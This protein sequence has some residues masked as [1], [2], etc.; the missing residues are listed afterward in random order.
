MEKHIYII[1]PYAFMAK[2]YFKLPPA[3]LA[4]MSYVHCSPPH[5]YFVRHEDV[6]IPKHKHPFKGETTLK[7]SQIINKPTSESTE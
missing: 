1:S 7:L 6:K 5:H 4:S 2:T 3:A